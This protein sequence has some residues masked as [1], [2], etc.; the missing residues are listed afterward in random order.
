MEWSFHFL[1]SLIFAVVV[2]SAAAVTAQEPESSSAIPI[3]VLEGQSFAGEF[4]PADESSG[5]PDDFVFS[6]GKFYS[7]Q[8]LEYGFEAGPYWVRADGDRLYFFAE[9]TSEEN[10]VMTYEGSIS[11]TAIYAQIEWIKP[12]WYWTIKRNF[13]FQGSRNTNAAIEGTDP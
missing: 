2:L 6:D 1:R 8:C 7:R 13:R 12:R 10:G 9:L 3:D 5:R 11:G 4:T